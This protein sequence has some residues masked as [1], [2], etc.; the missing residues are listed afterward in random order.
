MNA[1]STTITLQR[2]NGLPFDVVLAL[3]VPVEDS[4][5]SWR[6]TVSASGLFE[7][8]GDVHGVDSFQAGV[9]ALQLLRT[10]VS[11]E[12]DAGASLFW[13]G[14]LTSLVEIFGR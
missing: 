10:L 12:V 8:L 2:K 1:W 7:K 3:G 4:N 11:A 9:L 6:C 14:E 13:D 5:G